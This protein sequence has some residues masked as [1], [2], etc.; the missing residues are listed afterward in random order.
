MKIAPHFVAAP[1]Q[2]AAL[3]AVRLVSGALP[4]RRHAG[5]LLIECLVYLAVF[6]IL[7]SIGFASFYLCWDHSAALVIA[8]D[9]MGAA[10]RAGERWRADVRAATGKISVQSTPEGELLRIPHGRNEIFYSYH[11]GAIRRKLAS[12]GS[13]E[14][15]FAKVT[16]SQMQTETR[17][18][19]TAWRWELDLPLRRSETQLPLLFTFEAAQKP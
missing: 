8:T 4:R 12:A 5:I 1:R 14:L 18:G 15:V 19:V 13:A 6:T 17:D 10:L 9:D 2:S 16:S 7:T 11:G 3:P